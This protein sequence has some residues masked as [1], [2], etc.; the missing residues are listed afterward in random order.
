MYAGCIVLD[1]IVHVLIA[2]NIFTEY[3]IK[4]NAIP[5]KE[6]VPRISQGLIVDFPFKSS[7]ASVSKGKASNGPRV[8]FSQF[9]LLVV[10]PYDDAES[11]WYSQ[12]EEHQFK[13]EMF[14]DV[15]RVGDL[16]RDAT[17]ALISGEILCNCV[18]IENYLSTSTARHVSK[19]KKRH[20]LVV[21]LAQRF[22]ASADMIEKLSEI[23]RDS[24]RSSRKRAEKIAATRLLF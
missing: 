4:M 22:N 11:K 24:S 20:S 17:P 21:R 16:F 9:S 18:G 19:Q 10:I 8:R 14:A 13:Q 23:S 2:H 6:E 12:R 3:P 7:V 1:V 5:S 15:Q